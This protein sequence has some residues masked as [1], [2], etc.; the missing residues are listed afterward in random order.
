[1][2]FIKYLI[3]MTVINVTIEKPPNKKYAVSKNARKSFSNTISRSALTHLLINFKETTHYELVQC[4]CSK[5]TSK[6]TTEEF[7]KMT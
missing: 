4:F 2:L 7:W 6:H 3:V 5:Q 1:M